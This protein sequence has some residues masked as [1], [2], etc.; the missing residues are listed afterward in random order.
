DTQT[1]DSY[2][3]SLHDALP[4]SRNHLSLYT[5]NPD[6]TDLQYHYGF[7]SL[8]TTPLVQSLTLFRPQE[9][10][11][12]RIAAILKRRSEFLGGDMVVIDTENFVE[13]V[14]PINGSGGEAQARIYHLDIATDDERSRNGVFSSLHPLF[15]GTNRLLVSWSQ[16]RLQ[17]IATGRLVP[18]TDEWWE[19]DTTE[20]APP[21]FGI[22]I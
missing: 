9:M 2:T 14:V 10:P 22:W 21:L 8:N 5:V 18:C 3:L 17:V 20:I 13:N 16:C 19:D 15:D 1:S 11:D 7:N 6:G 4:I 12:R